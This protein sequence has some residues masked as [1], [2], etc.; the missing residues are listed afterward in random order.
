MSNYNC[1]QC[2][3][4]ILDIPGW[5][6]EK[7]VCSKYVPYS[8]RHNITDPD[9][10]GLLDYIERVIWWD[11]EQKQERVYNFYMW[12]EFYVFFENG[13]LTSKIWRAWK[14]D[15]F[16][17]WWIDLDYT[18]EVDKKVFFATYKTLLSCIRD[19]YQK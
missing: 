18:L 10:G 5:P 17:T 4:P 7:H 13:I 12:K 1:P 15:V 11:I 19:L 6:N 16:V 9:F 2:G 8:Q 3:E 14:T